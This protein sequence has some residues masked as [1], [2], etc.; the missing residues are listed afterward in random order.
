MQK[1]QW[2]FVNRPRQVPDLKLCASDFFEY[3]VAMLIGKNQLTALE[4]M[5]PLVKTSVD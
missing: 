2:G 4:S 1:N 3:H 5:R